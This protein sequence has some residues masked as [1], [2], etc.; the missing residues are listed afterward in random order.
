MDNKILI[1]SV[2]IA[3]VVW[4]AMFVDLYKS[5]LS[6]GDQGRRER[7]DSLI[8]ASHRVALY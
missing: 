3:I 4:L 8:S 5:D 2:S 1:K 6:V 7:A